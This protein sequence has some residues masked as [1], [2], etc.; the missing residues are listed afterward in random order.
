MIDDLKLPVGLDGRAVRHVAGGIRVRAHRHVELEV[1]LVVRGT[2]S[3]LLDSRRYELTPGTLTWLFPGQDH[4]LVDESADHELWWAVFTPDLIARSA[5]VPHT[6]PLLADDPS[7]WFSRRIGTGR[8]RRLHM[9]FGEVSEAETRDAALANAGLAYL[10]AF[11]WRAFLDGDALDAG[12]A[13]H[14]AVR[15]VAQMLQTD[16]E[17][18]DLVRLADI[19]DLS[20]AHLS[21]LFKAQIG[22]SISRYRNQ[23][24]LRRFLMAYEGGERSTMLAAAMAAGFGSYAQFYRVFRAETGR[25]PSTLRTAPEESALTATPNSRVESGRLA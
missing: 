24:R 1:N 23:Q 16:P 13:V 5:R 25:T 2:A 6:R 17:T 8:A 9:L 22:I 4:V 12:V 11:A 15:K 14:P 7:G 19:A 21:R 18:G 20:P 10:L 3:Y